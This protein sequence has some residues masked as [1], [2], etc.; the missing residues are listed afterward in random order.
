VIEALAPCQRCHAA[1]EQ[2]D[3]RCAICGTQVPAQAQVVADA[4]E[5]LRCDGCG[6]A[7]KYEVSERAPK[8]GFCAHVMHVEKVEDPM[9]QTAWW[10]RFRVPKQ[11]ADAA[12]TQWFGGLGFLRPSDL[13]S[14]ATIEGLKPL[15]WVAWVFDA[16]AF[17]SWAADSNAGSRRSAWAPHS[18]QCE[19]VFERIV[20]P[21]TRGLS[22]KE[23]N[24]LATSLYLDDGQDTA[25][26][27]SEG[28]VEQF[29]VQRSE[30]RAQIVDGATAIA[31]SRVEQN[32]IPGSSFR[33]VQ[34]E[35]VLRGLHTRRCAFPA[36][37]L[38]YRYRNKVY[39]AVING[40]DASC[41][42]GQAP[43]SVWKILGLCVLAGAVIAVVVALISAS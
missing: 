2:G 16:T 14:T 20:V 36:Y 39:R 28:V 22:R 38:A 5:I 18:G 8:C 23:T 4:I 19:L 25:P 3:L 24:H 40:Q 37:V 33:N 30:S 42:T 17:V 35:L 27:D 34:V 9:E 6:A 15:W 41:V 26:A 29:D 10:G 11:E 1:V 32:Y 43:Y 12:L 31:R 13:R 21:A 7:V